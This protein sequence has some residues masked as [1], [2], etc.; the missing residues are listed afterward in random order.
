[1]NL[2]VASAF[3]HLASK[4]GSIMTSLFAPPATCSAEEWDSACVILLGIRGGRELPLTSST[5]E[6]KFTPEGRT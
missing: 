4:T 1:V 3:H 6:D 5:T 2:L